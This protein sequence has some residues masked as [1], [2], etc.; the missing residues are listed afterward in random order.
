MDFSSLWLCRG[1]I[2]NSHSA[3]AANGRI[4]PLAYGNWA[5]QPTIPLYVAP[6]ISAANFDWKSGCC[7]VL[8]SLA[9]FVLRG[10]D[11]LAICPG[12]TVAL[13]AVP[14]AFETVSW[15][16][17]GSLDNP[18]RRQ[19]QASPEFTTTYAVEALRVGEGFNLVRNGDFNDG[20]EGFSSE[21]VYTPTATFNQG[22]YGIMPTPRDFNANFAD[23]ADHTGVSG[24]MMVV[25]GSTVRGEEVWCQT[26]DVEPNTNYAF[27]A[28]F[29][30]LISQNPG[31]LQFSING[32][33]LGA[34]LDVGF[35]L[36]DWQQFFEVWN[37]GSATQ[38]RLCI[39]NQNTEPNG[40]DFVLD[41]I[42]FFQVEEDYRDTVTV[43]VLEPRFGELDTFACPNLPIMINGQSL[44]ANSSV[45]QTLTSSVGCDSLLTVNVSLLDTVFRDI[46]VDTLCPGDT[47]RWR[48]E[49]ILS[50]TTVCQTVPIDATCDSLICLEAVYLT[51]TAIVGNLQLPSCFGDSDGQLRVRADAGKPPYLYQWDTG[52][53]DSLLAGVPAGS[54]TVTVT[55]QRECRASRTFQ[56][57]QPDALR[58]IPQVTDVRCHGQRNGQV[59]GRASGGSPPFEFQ[60]ARDPFRPDSLFAGLPTG[61]YPLKI[62]DIN[63]CRDSTLATINEPPPINLRIDPV[64]SVL[65]GES[66][67]LTASWEAVV[68]PVQLNWSPPELLGCTTCPNP[69][70]RPFNNTTFSLTLTDRNGCR[71]S[72]SIA[73]TVDKNYQVFFPNAFSPNDDGQN[74][75]FRAFGGSNIE[76]VLSFRVFD[77]W[78]SLQ[79]EGENCLI[80]DDAC[81]WDGEEAAPGIYLYTAEVRFIDGETVVF[82]G[83]VLLVR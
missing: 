51:E 81:A 33:L 16:P 31:R 24:L 62:R 73:L 58:L 80:G 68:P 77:R 44:M 26:I 7:L 66:E 60:I 39:T 9:V 57:S 23:C 49:V 74:D 61:N 53:A 17:A 37:S 34:P 41:D 54:Y 50:D 30:N 28:W 42:A 25:D 3:G 67:E 72:A 12:D 20:N 13:P 69:E 29:A 55:D 59:L 2:R 21:Y 27:S 11:T 78:G 8:W 63:G 64:A 52:L 1:L 22:Y 83:D 75:R 56:L 19:P 14:A 38:A 65:L 79:Y 15:N 32:A 48:G 18:N 43:E 40:N 71:D 82:S 6:M 46:R 10:Q 70:A 36:C 5:V 76:G 47:L 4:R 35:A 45:V